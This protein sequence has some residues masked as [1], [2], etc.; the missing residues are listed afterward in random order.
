MLMTKNQPWNIDTVELYPVKI[1]WLGSKITFCIMHLYRADNTEVDFFYWQASFL[2]LCA[3]C[4]FQLLTDTIT[5]EKDVLRQIFSSHKEK[6]I[7]VATIFSC[8]DSN[9]MKRQSFI[10]KLVLLFLAKVMSESG[11][12]PRSSQLHLHLWKDLKSNC[13]TTYSSPRVFL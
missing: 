8:T 13:L 5:K 11:K 7:S 9:I 1:I 6:D 12:E 4:L 2:S 10:I 3:S